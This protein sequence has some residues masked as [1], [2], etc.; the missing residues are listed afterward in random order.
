MVNKNKFGHIDLAQGIGTNFSSNKY[1]Y[2]RI[3]FLR[4]ITHYDNLN[5]CYLHMTDC[6][7]Q[8]KNI[9]TRDQDKIF[10]NTRHNVYV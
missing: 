9:S 7:I 8:A 2:K 5:N 10:Y 1:M 4:N 6:Q 3:K